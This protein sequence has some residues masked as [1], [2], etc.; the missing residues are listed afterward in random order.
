MW[1]ATYPVVELDGFDD[2]LVGIQQGPNV[3]FVGDELDISN[4]GSSRHLGFVKIVLYLGALRNVL[5][6]S[7]DKLYK[8]G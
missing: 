2:P 6:L 5:D 1:L 3:F 8:M 7:I 4:D